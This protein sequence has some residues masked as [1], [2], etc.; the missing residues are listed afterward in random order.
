MTIGALAKASGVG[1]ETVRFYQRKGLLEVPAA[2][3]GYRSYD[4]SH[5]ERL[6]F[7]KR[8][9]GIGFTLEEIAE[10]L[11]LNDSRDHATARA[12]AGE[13]LARIEQ[14]IQQLHTMAAAL[15]QLVDNCQHG[16]EGMPC[17]IIRLS[18][19][20]DGNPPHL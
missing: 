20:D 17:P 7:I 6:R 9:Q 1:I 16:G 4:G 10:L 8:A 15:R 19:A 3:Q 13:K 2:P 11:S 12:L 14:R 18:L 5:I